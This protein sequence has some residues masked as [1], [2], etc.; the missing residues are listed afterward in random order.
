MPDNRW[1]DNEIDGILGGDPELTELADRVRASRPEPA[2]DPRFQAVLRA[3]LMREAGSTAQSPSAGK[4]RVARAPRAVRAPRQSWWRGSRLAWGG[5]GLGVALVA[6]AVFTVANTRLQDHQVTY[7]SPVA[8]RHAVSPD[9][10]ITVAFSQPMDQ[11]AVVAGLHIRPATQVTTA[12]QGNNLLITPTH[13]L[14]GNTPYTVTIDHLSAKAASGQLVAADIRISFGTA[15][16]PPETPKVATLAPASLGPVNAGTTL[17]FAGDGALVASSAPAPADAAP[18]ASPSATAAVGVPPA[19]AVSA[20]AGPSAGPA[21]SSGDAMVALRA[22]TSAVVLGSAA[23]AMAIAPNGRELA[24]ATP[25]TR[26]GITISV[27][28][29]GGSARTP[30]TTVAKPVLGLGWLSPDL[31][32]V[33]QADRIVSVDT[34]G[35]VTTV[36][37]LPA[38][39][40]RVLFARTGGHAFAAAA[41]HDGTLVTLASKDWRLLAGSRSSAAFSGDGSTVAWID[42]TGAAGSRLLTSPVDRDASVRVPLDPT[43]T[44]L[45]EVA[46]DDAGSKAAVV[47]QP[48]G[49]SAELDVLSLP[50]GTIVA[51]GPAATHP[52][53]GAQPAAIA[54]AAGGQAQLAPLPGGGGHAAVNTLPDAAAT[55]LQAFVDAQVKG[56]PG[57]MNALTAPT[58][59]AMT[60]TP[61]GLTRA[62]VV[63]S[64]TNADGTVAAAARLIIDPAGARALP[65]FAD[66][67][68]V[69]APATDG[70]H[71]LVSKLTVGAVH[72]EPAGPHVLHVTR[73]SSPAGKLVLQVAFDSDLA[74]ASVSRAI[75][76]RSLAG[77]TLPAT[78]EYDAAA[79]TATVTLDAP[80]SGPVTLRV[81]TTL[82]DVDGDALAA[83]FSILAGG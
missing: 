22:G 69:L 82:V 28:T 72:D 54:F 36:T 53:F 12:W 44:R 19:P 76:V 8:E 26:G 71:Y 40:T 43:A 41:D 39:T 56:D 73:S 45:S 51:R 34:H 29:V 68:L 52:V 47:S 10:V 48:A 5:A 21:V 20:S 57:A 9:N 50:A 65:S 16:T 30:L 79:R 17:L 27:G 25:A 74:A 24:V 63:G 66:E 77:E 13:H 7:M 6:A 2:L 42:D 23:D 37:T 67:T 78:V 38:G 35:V 61:S 32:L 46:L 80:A 62:Y 4:Q 70:G 14:A 3:Q 33:A 83:V 31:V 64:A 1:L 15:P 75:T 59:D 18:A 55:T 58:V 81:D 11:A 49:G 60:A